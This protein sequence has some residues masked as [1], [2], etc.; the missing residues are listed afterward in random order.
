MN[1][2]QQFHKYQCKFILL[3]RGFQFA[4][5]KNAILSIVKKT[6]F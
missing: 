6:Y 5:L 1:K 3:L 4:N 2:I